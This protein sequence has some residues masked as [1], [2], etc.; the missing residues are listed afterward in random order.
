MRSLEIGMLMIE[1][2]IAPDILTL[3]DTGEEDVG[4]VLKTSQDISR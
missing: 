3:V 2:T 1:C 4:D